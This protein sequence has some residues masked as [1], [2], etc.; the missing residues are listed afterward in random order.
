MTLRELYGYGRKELEEKG[1]NEA[2][3]NAWYLLQSCL[4]K[5]PFSY[6][7]SRYFL[8][9]NQEA[10]LEVKKE[11]EEKISARKKHIPLEY[12]TGY[13]E[14][15]GL[16]F[17]VNE[18]VLIPRQDTELLV[19]LALP[20]AKGKR[21]LDLCTGSG[22]IG[23]SIAAL[24]NPFC[25]TLSDISR[26]AIEVARRNQR[27]LEKMG[28]WKERK[29]TIEFAIGDLWDAIHD[30]YDLILS[31]P[32]YIETSELS[33]LMPEVIEHEPVSALDGGESGLDFYEKIVDGAKGYLRQE[34]ILMVE[35]GYNQGE[36]V[37]QLMEDNGFVN[38]QIKKDLNGLH[39]VV[40]GNLKKKG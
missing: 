32:P 8:E 15:M 36:A 11:Y 21:V 20:E 9:Q 19:E 26:E 7:R 22:C 25:V 6:S 18:S 1:M 31:N 34:G 30:S 37:K 38:V 5:E 39:R 12:I 28:Q 4:E 13:T 24:G 10:P 27:Y 17:W 23:L 2:D 35:I 40:R 14:F 33:G 3:L 16:P 29:P